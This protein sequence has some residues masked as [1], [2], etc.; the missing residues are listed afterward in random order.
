M[1]HSRL[2]VALLSLCP[3]VLMGCEPKTTKLD[4]IL[5]TSVDLN[6]AACDPDFVRENVSENGYR[7]CDGGQGLQRCNPIFYGL[8]ETVEPHWGTCIPAQD[9]TEGDSVNHYP[10]DTQCDQTI[11]CVQVEDVTTW[12]EV[13]P[14]DTPL[15]LRFS[16]SPVRY[17]SLDAAGSTPAFAAGGSC[18]S[19]DWPTSDTPWLVLDRNENGTIDGG[20]ELFGSGT[21]L[22]NGQRASQGFEA[23]AELDDN[24]DGRLDALDGSFARLLLWADHNGDRQ[25]QPRELTPLIE[26]GVSR[27][28]VEFEVRMQC[29]ERGN[30]GRERAAF[31]FNAG[32]TARVGEVVDVYLPC[33]G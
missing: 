31:E 28:S 15:V 32:A 14:C 2:F 9:C 26:A 22:R 18:T 20:H 16:D 24:H 8:E 27:L 10:Q 4:Q 11:Y 6:D 23:L 7:L 12:S 13:V 29:D 3:L 21:V 30:C 17:Q 19:N 25:S 33:R 5:D 1:T